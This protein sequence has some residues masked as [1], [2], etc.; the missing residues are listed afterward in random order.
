MSRLWQRTI[1]QCIRFGEGSAEFQLLQANVHTHA[2]RL[3]EVS[4]ARESGLG[5]ASK[6]A[7]RYDGSLA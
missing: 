4:Q 2:V 1:S 5:G 6:M 7:S 3:V